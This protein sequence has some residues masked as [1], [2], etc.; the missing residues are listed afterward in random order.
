METEAEP[1]E[2]DWELCKENV[3]PLRQGRRVDNL[4]AAFQSNNQEQSS[5][6]REERL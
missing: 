5:R 4:A 3:Q 1:E 6:L 2:G